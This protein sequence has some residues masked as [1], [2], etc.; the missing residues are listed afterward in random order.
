V[1]A[2][3]EDLQLCLSE[4][5][6]AFVE[7]RQPFAAFVGGMILFGN[8]GGHVGWGGSGTTLETVLG[9]FAVILVPVALVCGVIGFGHFLTAIS[10][11]RPKP[12]PARVSAAAHAG[13]RRRGPRP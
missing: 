3:T 12:K 7:D 8:R 5:Q 2:S 10:G 13:R 9:G 11:K 6:A 1:T 4:T